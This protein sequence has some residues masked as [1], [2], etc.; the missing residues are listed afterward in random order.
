MIE[1]EVNNMAVTGITD[2]MRQYEKNTEVIINNKPK[3]S[4]PYGIKRPD[5]MNVVGILAGLFVIFVIIGEMVI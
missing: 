1:I 3:Y 4:K 2:P 5:S